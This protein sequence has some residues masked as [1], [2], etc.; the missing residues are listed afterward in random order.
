ML[1]APV[2]KTGSSTSQT[3]SKIERMVRELNSQACYGLSAFETAP[4]ATSGGPSKRAYGRN[5]TDDL[6]LTMGALCRL[7]YIGVKIQKSV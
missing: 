1:P 3:T 7:S 5:R 6:A 2:F 4:V